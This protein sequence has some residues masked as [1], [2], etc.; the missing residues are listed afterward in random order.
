MR[1]KLKIMLGI[2]ADD[3][4]QDA[5]LDIIISSTR[6]RLKRLIGGVEPPA[7]MDDIILEVSI[8]RFNRIGSEGLSSHTVEGESLTFA[9]SDFD[10]FA[11][12]I[13]AFLSSQ[14]DSKRGKVRLL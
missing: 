6:L 4:E 1:N 11:D 14:K 3:K 7:T 2:A 10:S 13:Q 5:M 9:A 12:D 8:M